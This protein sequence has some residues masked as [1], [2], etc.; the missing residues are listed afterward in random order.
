[1]MV[2]FV[3]QCEKNS[4]KKTRRVLDTFADRIGDNVWKT[5]ITKDGLDTVHKMLKETASK[6]TAVSCHWIRGYRRSELL[7]V[8]G[9][10]NAFRQDGIVPVNY[11]YQELNLDNSKTNQNKIF[12]ANTKKQDLVKHLFSVGYLTYL[13]VKKFTD[14][15]HF[16]KA[17]FIAGVLHDIGKTDYHYQEW[18]LKFLS[19]VDNTVFMDGVHIDS[20]KFS[21]EKYPRHNEISLLLNRF[22]DY[23]SSLSNRV[24]NEFIENSIFWH[25]A[26]PIRKNECKKYRDLYKLLEK[27]FNTYS[28]DNLLS[29]V[30]T[31]LNQLNELIQEYDSNFNVNFRLITTELD[32]II[33]SF[34][35]ED[36]PKFKQYE[37]EDNLENYKK[38]VLENSK[39]SLLRSCLITADRLVSTLSTDE[40]NELVLDKKFKN[41]IDNFQNS[42]SNLLEEIKLCIANFNQKYGESPRNQL[43]AKIANELLRVQDIAVLRGPAGCGKTK[44]ALEWASNSQVKKLIWVC[45]RVLVCEGI[46]EDL[47][48]SEYLPNSKIEILTGE[49]KYLYVNNKK[50]ETPSGQEFSGDI[51]ITTIDQIVNSVITHRNTTTLVDFM[52]S[53]VVFDEF[54]EL[55]HLNGMNLFFSELISCKKFRGENAKTLLL[56]ATPND[57]FLSKFLEIDKEDIKYCETFNNS[58]YVFRLTP[59]EDVESLEN[60]LYKKYSPTTFVISNTAI[61][62][63]KSYIENLG[64]ENALLFHARFKKTDKSALFS[65]VYNAFK[66]NGLKNFDI[67]RSGPVIQASLNISCE[68]MVSE[69]TIAENLLQRL[70]RLDRFA[71]SSK[72]NKLNIAVP[73]SLLH[74]K[75]TSP[76]A[77]FLNQQ[78]CLN[79]AKE[80]L[81]YLVQNLIGKNLKLK[82][83]YQAYSH[84][85]EQASTEKSFIQDFLSALKQSVICINNK[86]HDPIC[87]PQKIKDK[88]NEK[89]K[90]KKTSLRGDSRFVQMA[91]CRIDEKGEIL[92]TNQ[93]ACNGVDEIYV[94]PLDEIESWD[95]RRDKDLLAYMHQKHHKIK[96]IKQEFN[97]NVLK[98]LALDADEPIYVSYIEEDLLLNNDL[99]NPNAIYYFESEAQ[100]IGA[101]SM[102]KLLN[103]TTDEV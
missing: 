51:V 96:K 24:L 18:I 46:F 9:K 20:G 56:S 6:S 32:D 27:G 85:Y 2:I 74:G 97:P 79:S 76:C 54:H 71:Q 13:L 70:G 3:S 92:S 80:W 11:T 83:I 86:V 37:L 36:L 68:N 40:L 28:F 41:L 59:F 48:S 39:N 89:K 88:K 69:F 33:Q 42:E 17:A 43:Q 7:W 38:M 64:S 55:I 53:H 65:K 63:Q 49:Y 47:S 22:I 91:V 102:S 44:I 94:M 25:H 45:P 26:K 61:T 100:P 29:D 31:V 78:H 67:L 73:Q 84:F 16:A 81:K 8:V 23:S 95:K 98:N 5:L 52:N 50:V 75:K 82:E 99:P 77:K 57:I 14:D 30:G 35:K 21:F 15:E 62:A 72:I 103:T 101:I 34:R 1:M 87:F 4:I 12:F 60:P 90:L 58:D 19:E 66:K 10:K 93:Y